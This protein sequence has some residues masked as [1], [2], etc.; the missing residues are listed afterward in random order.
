VLY[1]KESTRPT[2]PNKETHDVAV[3]F[4]EEF[5]ELPVWDGAAEEPE[6]DFAEAC[7]EA[8]EAWDEESE[9]VAEAGALAVPKATANDDTVSVSV[10]AVPSAAPLQR[11]TPEEN[12]QSYPKVRERASSA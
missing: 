11:A 7:E 4:V 3:S 10:N 1:S 2:R 6:P 12:V 9:F 5:F 8:E